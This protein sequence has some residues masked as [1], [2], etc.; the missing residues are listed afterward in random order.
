MRSCPFSY[1]HR[2]IR[3]AVLTSHKK[4]VRERVARVKPQRNPPVNPP[5]VL[6]MINIMFRQ[7]PP[8]RVAVCSRSLSQLTFSVA[9]QLFYTFTELL[10]RILPK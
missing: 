10:F 9:V 5:S 2:K 4:H 3:R 7:S 1:C 6:E 8:K